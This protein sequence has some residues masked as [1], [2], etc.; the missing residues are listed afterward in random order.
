MKS[1]LGLFV[2]A[3]LAVSIVGCGDS[4]SG[5]GGAGG[6]GGGGA[7]GTGG[8]GGTGG[9]GGVGGGTGGTGGV[10]GSA[11]V[12][13]AAYC[14][15]VTKNCTGENAQYAD[16]A[17]ETVCANFEEGKPADTMGATLNCHA[18]HAGAPA[19]GDPALHCAHAGPLGGGAMFCGSDCENFCD[20]AVKVCGQQGTP[21][22]A[23]K[24]ACMTE[25]AKFT[26]TATVPY[27][28]AATAGDSLACRA[29]HLTVASTTDANAMTHC[30][31]IAAASDTCK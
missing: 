5:S 10:G 1:I 11:G 4:S 18:Y 30:P 23:G 19:A 20:L 28:A 25:C 9:T 2:G 16:G 24:D 21:P 13:C 17:C 27:N 12:T 14:A 31:H 15:D 8:V 22:Y 6:T 7:G 26:D 3:L 29:Y